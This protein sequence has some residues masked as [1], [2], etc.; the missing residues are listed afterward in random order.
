M[1]ASG[2]GYFIIPYTISNY[3]ADDIKTPS[4]S[5]D[6]QEFEDAEKS[7]NERLEKLVSINGTQTATSFHKRLGEIMWNYCGM[8]RNENGLKKAKQMLKELK[9]E[10]WTDLI[11]PRD[12]YSVNQELE[13]AGR[14]A[15]YFEIADLMV[16][17]AL[18]R[19]ESCGA[20]FREESQTPEGEA[21]RDD[22]NFSYVAAWEYTGE[23]KPHKLHKEELKFENVKVQVRSY[24]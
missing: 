3:L 10:F 24:K 16:N 18:N 6:K 2:D 15:D 17:D 20:H 13:K 8:S 14:V 1:Q 5:T 12:L 21:L 23:S 22:K 7:V 4:I 11:I 19:T 9:E